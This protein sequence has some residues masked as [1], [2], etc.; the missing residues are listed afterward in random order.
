MKH[1]LT[2]LLAILI[3]LAIES[4]VSANDDAVIKQVSRIVEEVRIASYPELNDAEIEIEL[5]DS[6][7]DYFQTRFTFTSFLLGRKLRCLLKVNRNLFAD[8][9]PDDGLR[10]IIA[11]ELGHAL[12]FKSGNR[13]K[14][15]GLVR[16][17]CKGFTAR[18]ER[19][20]DMQAIARG[21]GQGL[22]SYRAWLYGQIPT[23]NLAEKKRNYFS[24]EEIDVL[25]LK[26][27]A[28]PELLKQW[29]KR[30]PCSLKEIRLAMKA[31]EGFISIQLL[32]KALSEARRRHQPLIGCSWN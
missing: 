10:A 14:L 26:L 16:L 1:A 17:V 11:H 22:K 19:G 7:S 2:I 31:S 21:Y 32:R 13:I 30:P 28:Q 29:L 9:V 8:N 5:F 20:T 18:F 23:K 24:P 3:A 15:L 6:Q 27:L 4:N 25:E 12:Y